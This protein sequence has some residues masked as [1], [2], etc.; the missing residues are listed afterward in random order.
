MQ[1]PHISH[2]STI[3]L[4]TTSIFHLERDTPFDIPRK[5]NGDHVNGKMSI[6]RGFTTLCERQANTSLIQSDP[7]S[8]ELHE[9]LVCVPSVLFV[10]YEATGNR[11]VRRGTLM[12]SDLY[13]L[14]VISTILLVHMEPPWPTELPRVSN[15]GNYTHGLTQKYQVDLKSTSLFQTTQGVYQSK[16]VRKPRE[17]NWPRPSYTQLV[18]KRC[19]IREAITPNRSDGEEHGIMVKSRALVQKLHCLEKV[20]L[21]INIIDKTI[22]VTCSL[23][24]HLVCNCH[25]PLQ[26]KYPANGQV[27]VS[28]TAY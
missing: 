15:F 25:H 14:R 4:H 3:F 17:L 12:G 10:A 24:H 28:T 16:P 5:Q 13:I 21:Y 23:N 2:I 26:R 19:P 1:H 7:F 6:N 8:L 18:H 27:F 22:E 9:G 11:E 20:F